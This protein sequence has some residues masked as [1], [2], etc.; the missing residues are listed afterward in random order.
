MANAAL[1]ATTWVGT[2]TDATLGSNWDFG[3]PDE[4]NIDVFIGAT[5]TTSL[6]GFGALRARGTL[7]VTGNFA[8]GEEVVI[9]A[10]TYTFVDPAAPSADGEVDVGGDAEAS[11]DNLFDAINLVAGGDYGASMTIH[12]T[13]T[14]IL[15][16]ATFLTVAAKNAGTGG[17]SIVST[18]DGGNASWGAGT[19]AGGAAVGALMQNAYTD[20]AWPGDINSSGT[21]AE[22]EFNKFFHRGSG[23]VYLKVNTGQRL[24]VDSTNLVLAAQII[25]TSG[26]ISI[27]VVAGT[28]T[29]D[30]NG[31]TNAAHRIAITEATD[32][33][34]KLTITGSG[35]VPILTTSGGFVICNGPA[36]TL[37]VAGGRTQFISG[38]LT[39][40][41]NT[42]QF[43]FESTSTLISAF[44]LSG[45]FD[46]T[47][48]AAAKTVTTLW[49]YLTATLI[50][51][52]DFDTISTLN[53]IGVD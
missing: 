8:N 33:P 9:D 45:T 11:L 2:T 37:M 16:T 38:V 10:K 19:L 23:T 26:L 6:V 30:Q 13:V 32:I 46:M 17:N 48:T 14:A 20:P 4:N 52:T 7:T 47:T 12:P 53:R 41:F 5:P 35:T 24:I 40:L 21:E 1:T 31:V 36:I 34:T 42:G 28:A 43:D 51:R 15:N 25:V 49:Q 27:E 50:R 39:E 18:T 3:V 29:V 22:I 44:N